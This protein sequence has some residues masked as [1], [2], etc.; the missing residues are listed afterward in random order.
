M[1]GAIVRRPRSMQD[2]QSR[3]VRKAGRRRARRSVDVHLRACAEGVHECA[4][5]GRR[6]APCGAGSGGAPRVSAR[7]C[8]L[9]RAPAPARAWRWPT[10][11]AARS[12]ASTRESRSGCSPSGQRGRRGRE[13]DASSV[14]RRA[15]G[16]IAPFV[17][18]RRTGHRHCTRRTPRAQAGCAR[19]ARSSP[20]SFQRR[21]AQYHCSGWRSTR[22]SST[23]L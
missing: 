5:R 13:E 12:T 14:A 21:C 23:A 3:R 11:R 19:G 6:D 1:R 15:I 10:T 20:A 4:Q 18:R 9:A 7:R 22:R 17:Q 8:S 16:W 2:N